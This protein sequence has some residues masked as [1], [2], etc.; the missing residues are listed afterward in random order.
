MSTYRGVPVPERFPPNA[1]ELKHWK[2]GVDAALDVAAPLLDNL[3]D[4]EPC[5]LD[6]HGYC[7]THWGG[8]VTEC[9]NRLA[10]EFLAQAA[11]PETVWRWFGPGTGPVDLYWCKDHRPA[12]AVQEVPVSEIHPSGPL[13]CTHCGKA[14]R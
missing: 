3:T 2:Q 14:V 6:H 13:H 5:S 8:A 12:V 11:L 4:D 1:W 10:E 7:Q 9:A